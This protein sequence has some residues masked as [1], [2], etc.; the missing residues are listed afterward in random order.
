M[1]ERAG[2]WLCT[3]SLVTDLF[4]AVSWA[5][6]HLFHDFKITPARIKKALCFTLREDW[7]RIGSRGLGWSGREHLR[8]VLHWRCMSTEFRADRLVDSLSLPSETGRWRCSGSSME[9]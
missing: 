7:K 1:T 9:V 2:S 8:E 3:I 5:L 6:F 4:V